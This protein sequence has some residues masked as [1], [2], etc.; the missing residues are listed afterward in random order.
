MEKMV[1][2]AREPCGCITGMA[3]DEPELAKETAKDVA[4]WIQGG[5]HVERVSGEV[6]KNSFGVCPREPA[7]FWHWKDCGKKCPLP[8][9]YP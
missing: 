1:Y 5:R 3:A 9:D 6:A 4:S 8:N 2:I 7:R